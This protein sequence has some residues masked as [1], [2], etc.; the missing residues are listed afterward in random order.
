MEEEL[1]T[2]ADSLLDRIACKVG[3]DFR[4]Q[5]VSY[6]ACRQRGP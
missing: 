5:S 1:R 4:D 6:S 2:A 3:T